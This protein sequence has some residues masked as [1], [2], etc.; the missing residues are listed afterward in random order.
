MSSQEEMPTIDILPSPVSPPP[1]SEPELTS[2]VSPPQSPKT[3][4][5]T[6]PITFPFLPPTRY[7][8]LS[9]PDLSTE[10]ERLAH[11]LSHSA[12]KRLRKAPPSDSAAD[13]GAGEEGA[14]EGDAKIEESE[15]AEMDSVSFQPCKLKKAANQDRYTSADWVFGEEEKGLWRFAAVF[16][17]H[18]GSELAEYV[19]NTL[20]DMI[21]KALEEILLSDQGSEERDGIVE[22]I[23]N[24]LKETII[25]LDTQVRDDFL[26]IFLDP[27]SED[28]T[29]SQEVTGDADPNADPK[30]KAALEKVEAMSVEEIKQLINDHDPEAET[31]TTSEGL[32]SEENS[33]GEKG[34]KKEKN[35]TLVTRIMR[36][37]TALITL[38]DPQRENLWVANL[39]DCQATLVSSS[40]TDPEGK[41][42]FTG[43][44]V[45]QN[46][47]IDNPAESKRV[48]G[49]HPDEEGVVVHNHLTGSRVLGAIMVSRALG[50][51]LFK[52]PSLFTRKVILNASP[53]LKVSV[54][55]E[56]YLDRIK[57]PP[58]V[59][60]VAEI[61]HR[62]LSTSGKEAGKQ[63]KYIVLSS[64]GLSDLYRSKSDEETRRQWAE[65]VGNAGVGKKNKALELLKAA[66]GGPNEDRMSM[67]LKLEREGRWM[68]DTT[69]VVM[70]LS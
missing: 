2:P 6:T 37:T 20:P 66:I 35:H 19:V 5:R 44:L 53:G 48:A 21:R 49:E 26:G 18:G 3:F 56:S 70:A 43:D 38:V 67:Y 41:E 57:T 31:E 7:R 40:Q 29:E 47:N 11:P 58:Y 51:F 36:G 68:D 34:K 1:P 9:E 61:H 15:D 17:G 64:D 39:G 59:S 16:D 33:H 22:R 46:H 8:V 13:G 28:A 4:A 14:K 24:M 62:K 10:L 50:D 63:E 32:T 45:T 52:L 30:I 42:T 54:P 69:I 65:V 55:V 25:R 27:S 60:N 12:P 23:S